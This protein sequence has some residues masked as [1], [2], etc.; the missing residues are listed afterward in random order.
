[1]IQDDE[2][3]IQAKVCDSGER[4]TNEVWA[5]RTG[6]IPGTDYFKYAG[7]SAFLGLLMAHLWFV[8]ENIGVY[9]Q[10]GAFGAITLRA[11]IYGVGYYLVIVMIALV[12]KVS[13]TRWLFWML[14]MML[15]MI[16][17]GT[18]I[19]N[20]IFADY[21]MSIGRGGTT[22]LSSGDITIIS[23]FV[24]AFPEEIYKLIAY[25]FPLWYAKSNRTVFG[26]ISLAAVAG[27]LFGFLENVTPGYIRQDLKG[28][29][30]RFI[31]CVLGHSS[32]AMTGSM[33]LAYMK[34][35]IM[36][37]RWFWYPMMLIIPVVQHG[38]YDIAAFSNGWWVW[39]WG[40]FVMVTPY[41]MLYPIIKKEKEMLLH[42]TVVVHVFV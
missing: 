36:S 15:V 41:L 10:P 28:I 29:F 35:G 42:N 31:W 4:K 5:L 14:L 19:R 33:F 24:A 27:A 25:S 32:M 34:C 1:M 26:A 11:A 22:K 30:L 20:L 9:G 7:L 17:V 40:I 39:P 23:F 2:G 12:L 18:I 6:V 13:N 37:D 16:I 8:Y 38:V 21:I 3:N